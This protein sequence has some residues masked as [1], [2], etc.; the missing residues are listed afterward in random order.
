VRLVGYL[1]GRH[2]LVTKERAWKIVQQRNI[3]EDRGLDVHGLGQTK[4]GAFF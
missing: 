4:L 1:S 3:L 2:L